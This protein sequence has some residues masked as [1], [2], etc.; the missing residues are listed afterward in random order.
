MLEAVIG[1]VVLITAAA[2]VYL[3]YT[4]SGM[5]TSEVYVLTARFDDAGGISEGSDVKM[6]G[7]KIGVV[8][9]L[10]IDTQYQA[11]AELSVKAGI[12]IPDD[13]SAAIVSDGIMGNK[14]IS[15]ITGF[16]Q[17]NFDPGAEIAITRSAVNL[18]TLIDRF[19]AG[20]KDGGNEA[21]NDTKP[22]THGSSPS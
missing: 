14:F 21:A 12:V 6:S 9:K 22:T 8:K 17:T 5:D 15:I 20:G 13:S 11:K 2:S 4:S 18:E 7:I 3:A 19:V 16:S 1:A 10:S